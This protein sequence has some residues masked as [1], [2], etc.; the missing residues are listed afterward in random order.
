MVKTNTWTATDCHLI[1]MHRSKQVENQ[2]SRRIRMLP[3]AQDR[4]QAGWIMVSQRLHCQVRNTMN[5]GNLDSDKRNQERRASDPMAGNQAKNLGFQGELTN[6]TVQACLLSN[7]L[8]FQAIN[9]KTMSNKR[10]LTDSWAQIMNVQ[11]T[12]KVCRIKHPANVMTTNQ[13]WIWLKHNTP[14]TTSD[15]S[16]ISFPVSTTKLLVQAPGVESRHLRPKE[17]TYLH[18]TRNLYTI[19]QEA[20]EWIKEESWLMTAIWAKVK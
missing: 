1:L 5:Y 6:K 14:E 10:W 12:K 3:C 17:P 13:I 7:C 19:S 16:T 20:L 15:H 4:N 11:G 2:L 18:H 8:L 9:S